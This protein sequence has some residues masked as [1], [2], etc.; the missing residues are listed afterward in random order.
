MKT[1]YIFLISLCSFVLFPLISEAQ[2]SEEVESFILSGK[3]V[4]ASTLEGIPFSHIKLDDTYWGVICDSLGFFKVT[5]KP[6]QNLKVSSLGF[7][8]KITPVTSEVTDG[9]AFQEVSLERVSFML[10]EVDIYSLGTWGQFKENFVKMELPNEENIA[11]NFDYGNLRAIYGTKEAPIPGMLKG[12]GVGGGIGFN[13]KSRDN[14][15]REHVA[16]LKSREYKVEIL[17]NKFNKQLVEDI[18]QEKGA[19]L[20]A[21][22]VYITEREHFTYQ[23]RDIYIQ[24]R[25]KAHYDTFVLEYVEGEYNYAMGDSTKTLKNHLRPVDKH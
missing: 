21:L 19:R 25:I 23:T 14:K 24:Q 10:E 6:N 1:F 5:V 18:T 17:K 13:G 4:D 15:S 16:K 8:E 9:S 22:M 20:E 3:V 12:F 11:A 7:A 2:E